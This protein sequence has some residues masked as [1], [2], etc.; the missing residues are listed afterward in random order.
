MSYSADHKGCWP[1]ANLDRKSVRQIKQQYKMFN[2]LEQA[3]SRP[4]LWERLKWKKEYVKKRK[5]DTYENMKK[6]VIG[7]I[8]Y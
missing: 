1:L 5:E 4:S 8:K 3:V 2:T 7:N 6:N